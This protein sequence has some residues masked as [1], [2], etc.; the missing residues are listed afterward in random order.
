[1]RALQKQVGCFNHRV[2]TMVADKLKRMWLDERFALEIRIKQPKGQLPS[3]SYNHNT[4]KTLRT[5]L[6]PSSGYK[7]LTA[8][9]KCICND[10]FTDVLRAVSVLWL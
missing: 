7:F 8:T 1:M 9:M 3:S 10:F 4:L 2:V 5:S 6:I